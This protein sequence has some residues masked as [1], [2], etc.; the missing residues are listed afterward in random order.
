MLLCWGLTVGALTAYS[1]QQGRYFAYLSGWGGLDIANFLSALG[2]MDTTAGSAEALVLF[3]G[4][5]FAIPGAIVGA[6]LGTF[7]SGKLR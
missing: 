1:F 7:V 2:E 6:A 5:I 4:L 3:F